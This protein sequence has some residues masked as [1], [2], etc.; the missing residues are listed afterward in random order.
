M[1]Q[2]SIIEL[3]LCKLLTLQRAF[4]HKTALIVVAL[5]YPGYE[6]LPCDVTN[7]EK[8]LPLLILIFQGKK[9][10]G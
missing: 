8:S 3:M 2:S 6:I 4:F 1:S 7:L 10:L 9:Y 5:F